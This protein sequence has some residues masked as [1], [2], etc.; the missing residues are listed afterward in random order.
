MYIHIYTYACEHMSTWPFSQSLLAILGVIY[1]A[2]T[3]WE[4]IMFL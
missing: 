2:F 3:D 4:S 1:D